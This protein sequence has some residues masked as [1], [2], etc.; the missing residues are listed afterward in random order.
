MYLKTLTLCLCVSVAPSFLWAQEQP[1]WPGA[2]YD[3]A[4]P[5]IKSVLGH[6]HG[7]LITPPE[8]VAQYLQGKTDRNVAIIAE[9]TNETVETTRAVCWPDFAPDSRINWESIAAYQDWAVTDGL[10]LKAVS[11]AQAVDSLF[12]TAPGMP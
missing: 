4:I 10:M 2:K 1:L 7:E 6:D 5:T 11:R 3:A 8:G 9:A 12:V